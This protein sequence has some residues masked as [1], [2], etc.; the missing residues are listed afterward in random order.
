MQLIL[1]QAENFSAWGKKKEKNK[2]YKK[3][4]RLQFTAKKPSE[5]LL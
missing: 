2:D 5:K 1:L 4:M 3:Y